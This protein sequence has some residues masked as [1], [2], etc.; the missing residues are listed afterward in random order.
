MSIQKKICQSKFGELTLNPGP[1]NDFHWFC[2]ITITSNIFSGKIPISIMTKN[3]EISNVMIEF[4]EKIAF[5]IDDYLKSSIIF[6]KE[7]LNSEKEKYKIKENEYDL[8]AF[9]FANFPIDY[10]ELNFYEESD[11]WMIR[12]AEGKFDIC[13]PY[14]IAVWFKKDKPFDIENLEDSEVID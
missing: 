14:G 4:V 2:E 7:I 9:D 3:K 8:L 13:D 5:S 1:E 12:F 10:P 6:L 11:E